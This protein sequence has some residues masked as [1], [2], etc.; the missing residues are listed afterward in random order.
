[1]QLLDNPLEFAA[2][3]TAIGSSYYVLLIQK[4]APNLFS[5][6]NK[7]VFSAGHNSK[8]SATKATYE[9]HSSGNRSGSNSIQTD[10]YEY[11]CEMLGKDNVGTELGSD[12]KSQIDIVVRDKDNNYAFYEIKISY[13]VRLYIREA[14][15]QLWDT[16]FI[17]T[18][19]AVNS[20]KS[21][22]N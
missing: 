4:Q 10:L 11:F 2:D 16:H 12:F 19:D 6:T 15:G 3:D 14:L 5:E 18:V 9:R 22:T 8:K 21:W 1:L 17:Q 7:F 20:L 13:S